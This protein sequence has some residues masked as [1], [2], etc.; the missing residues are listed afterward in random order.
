MSKIMQRIPD[1]NEPNRL[2]DGEVSDG[3]FYFWLGGDDDYANLG[4]LGEDEG[5]AED[6]LETDERIDVV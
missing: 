6:A 2:P 5:G 1:P 4:L 3:R